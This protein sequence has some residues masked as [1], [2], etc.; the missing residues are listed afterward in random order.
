MLQMSIK[1]R[2]T[3]W[4][5]TVTD[6]VGNVLVSGFSVSRLAARNRAAGALF[7]TLLTTTSRMS[8]LPRRSKR[9]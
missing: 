3:R 7:E 9:A 2:W 6:Q 4:E 1:R 8:K 5:W